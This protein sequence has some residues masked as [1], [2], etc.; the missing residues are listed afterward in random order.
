MRGGIFIETI[1]SL[2]IKLMPE[3]PDHAEIADLIV[4]GSVPGIQLQGICSR[5][6]PYEPGADKGGKYDQEP[7]EH[8]GG[9]DP[10]FR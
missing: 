1:H 2:R 6:Q 10:L 9:V 7:K 5:D 8:C 3:K 4:P